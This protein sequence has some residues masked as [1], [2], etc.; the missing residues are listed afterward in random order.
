MPPGKRTLNI[1]IH[2]KL[3]CARDADGLRRLDPPAPCALAARRRSGGGGG[4]GV[5]EGGLHRGGRR[6]RAM[7][8]KIEK[9]DAAGFRTVAV[10]ARCRGGVEPRVE[11]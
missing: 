5:E 2:K 9:R 11:A 1:L 7:G 4:V 8:K 3:P 10:V 6:G